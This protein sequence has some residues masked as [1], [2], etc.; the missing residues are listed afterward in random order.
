MEKDL[1]NAIKK[2]FLYDLKEGIIYLISHKDASFVVGIFFAF[3]SVAGALYV[4][5]IV[6]IQEL[7]RSMTRSIGIFGVFLFLGFLTGSYL[8]GKVGHIFSRVKA[9]FLSFILSGFFIV[10]FVFALRIAGLFWLGSVFIFLLGISISPV[11]ISGN[12]IIHETIDEGMRGR[13]FSLMGIIMN[14]GFILFMF[15]SSILAEHVDRMWIII[16]CGFIFSL[17]GVIGYVFS[18]RGRFTSFGS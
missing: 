3:M 17:V 15:L 18:K 6:F 4:V 14:G 7:T 16:A 13:V 10:L 8:Y 9:I 12:T 5:M 11:A 1:E 2:S